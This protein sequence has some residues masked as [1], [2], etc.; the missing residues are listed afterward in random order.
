MAYFTKGCKVYLLNPRSVRQKVGAGA[1]SGIGGIDKFHFMLIPEN[2]FKIDVREVL[3]PNVPLM[4]P[5]EDANQE[6]LKDVQGSN[7]IWDRK[8]MKVAS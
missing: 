2:W 3:Q 4:Y 8:Y 1:V 5:K 6:K 7:A